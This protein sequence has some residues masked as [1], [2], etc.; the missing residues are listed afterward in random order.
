MKPPAEATIGTFGGT[1]RPVALVDIP[2]T[3]L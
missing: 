3:L 1:L 2:L